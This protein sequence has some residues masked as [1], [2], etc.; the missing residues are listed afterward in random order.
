MRIL[1][2]QASNTIQFDKQQEALDNKNMEQAIEAAIEDADE[3]QH[4]KPPEF[5]L[6]AEIDKE[7]AFGRDKDDDDSGNAATPPHPD[8]EDEG[9]ASLAEDAAAW[10]A[11]LQEELLQECVDSPTPLTPKCTPTGQGRT[12]RALRIRENVAAWGGQREVAAKSLE[13]ECEEREEE[14]E[15]LRF[16]AKIAEEAA[17]VL[18][19]GQREG[20]VS[21]E[22]QIDDA[23]DMAQEDESANEAPA[24]MAAGADKA[25]GGGR[26]SAQSESEEENL[27]QQIAANVMREMAAAN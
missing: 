16:D 19:Q 2:E 26:R 14:E 9:L 24:A 3:G 21:I 8:A 18:P 22:D 13:K 27:D 1:Q 15:A 4:Y 12:S 11:G 17:E 6:E 20:D 10:E 5:D 23:I 7:V 25:R